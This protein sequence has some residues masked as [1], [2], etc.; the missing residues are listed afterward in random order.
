[1]AQVQDPVTGNI[2]ACGNT[3]LWRFNRAAGTWTQLASIPNNGSATY[4][5]A[6]VFDTARNRVVVLGDAYRTTTGIL[7]YDVATDAWST[8]NL[9]GALA[10]TV[11]AASG[12]FAHYNAK[13]DKYLF[14][15]GASTVI[16]VD[17]A[18]WATSARTTTGGSGMT[19][20]IN[21][22]FQKVAFVPSMRGYAYQVQGASKLWFLASE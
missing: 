1:M 3:K 17:P 12:D 5:Q 8:A 6:S 16:D 7:V 2:Y 21:G 9:T 13:L 18:T 4:Y 14:F 22:V 19:D 11:A 20:S 10:A 15:Q